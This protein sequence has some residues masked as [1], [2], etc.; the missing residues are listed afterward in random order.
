MNLVHALEPALPSYH[1]EIAIQIFRNNSDY[2]RSE[3]RHLFVVLADSAICNSMQE[4]KGEN[5]EAL[6]N[7]LLCMDDATQLSLERRVSNCGY[8]GHL[9]WIE[10]LLSL[11]QHPHPSWNGLISASLIDH[12]EEGV[13]KYLIT[14]TGERV[15]ERVSLLKD[16]VAARTIQGI[17]QR[18][19]S[20]EGSSASDPHAWPGG[21]V[22]DEKYFNE[23]SV[24]HDKP[25]SSSSLGSSGS[26][27]IMP[28][29][30]FSLVQGGDHD[31]ELGELP[32]TFPVPETDATFFSHSRASTWPN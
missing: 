32:Y 19:P 21:I 2:R 17:Q 18:Q 22:A 25:A 14:G 28:P 23:Q 20:T 11:A 13:Q 12:L 1:M 7:L 26:P 8:Y 4:D 31:I 30:P 6:R 9:P 27:Y 16:L 3:D 29:T 10:T 24:H 5:K 15:T